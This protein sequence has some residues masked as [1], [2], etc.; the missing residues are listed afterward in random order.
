MCY[1]IFHRGDLNGGFRARDCVPLLVQPTMH[2]PTTQAY[3]Y[4]DEAL[5]SVSS[6][7]PELANGFT[8]HAPMVIE[9]LCA[10]G[11]GDA[12]MHWLARYSRQ[13]TP[14]PPARQRIPEGDWEPALGQLDRFA[15]WQAFFEHEMH[16][17]S[18]KDVLDLWA[19][20]LAPGFSAAA[21]HGPI[22]VGHA[23]RA[24]NMAPT[25]ARL[26]E[27][28]KALGYWAATYKALP[29]DLF[30][31]VESAPPRQSIW[32]VPLLPHHQRRF[33]GSIT[34][35]LEGLDRFR[36]FKSALGLADLSGD[37]AVVLSE[38]TETFAHVYIANARDVLTSVIFVHAVT[39]IAA[40]RSIAS[41]VGSATKAQL[42]R[43]AWQAAC[44]IYAAF[45]S[46]PTSPEKL[47]PRNNSSEPLIER[48]I[49][50][51]DEHAIKFIETCLREDSIKA[52]DVY[53]LAAAHALDLLGES[54]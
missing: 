38:L 33:A 35:S 20:R 29:S 23:V 47:Q 36:P 16:E 2:E 18:W 24:L 50:S 22:R 43:Y 39:S 32:R 54:H 3:E 45:G 49:T 5:D 30:P 42:L 14:G 53:R 37:P 15:D 34:S 1:S 28:A 19:R 12:V 40:V 6:A 4:L 51:Q 11:R 25:P 52:A 48:A 8:N 17:R 41:H 10:M 44:A 27:F 31:K 13:L 46:N 7:G 21:T 9:A 26:R